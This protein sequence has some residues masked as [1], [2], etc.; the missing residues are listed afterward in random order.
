[1]YVVGR[2]KVC[3]AMVVVFSAVVIGFVPVVIVVTNVFVN[4]VVLVFGIVFIFWCSSM[5]WFVTR[6]VNSSVNHRCICLPCM[7]V[8]P[9]ASMQWLQRLLL[10]LVELVCHLGALRG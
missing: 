6:Y 3:A 5:S 2:D 1:M 10:E 4:G 8:C 9:V 7:F